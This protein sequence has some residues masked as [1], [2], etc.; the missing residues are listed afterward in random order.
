MN[1]E[2]ITYVHNYIAMNQDLLT[3]KYK[4]PMCYVLGVEMSP[5]LT[6]SF[7][8]TPLL[9]DPIEEDDWGDL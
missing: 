1:N 8:T 6:A 5:V 4:T 3:K 2:L 7:I 9:V